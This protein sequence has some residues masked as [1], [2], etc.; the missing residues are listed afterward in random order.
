MQSRLALSATLFLAICSVIFS[1][2]GTPYGHSYRY[3]IAWLISF[4][5]AI[6]QGALYPRHLPE[7]WTGAGG[8]D[9]FFYG[10]L[11]FFMAAGPARLL[12]PS[13]E[14]QA[15]LS[16]AGGLL[17]ALS[18][19]AFYLFSRRFL[20]IRP[21]LVAAL[22]YALMPYHLGVDWFV[23]QAIGEFAAYVFVPLAAA[24]L[25]SALRD[26]R[27]GLAFPLGVAGTILCH[28]PTALLAAHVFGAV[29]L[30]WAVGYRT[31]V[32]AAA[33]RVA[34]MGIAGL[35]LAGLYWVPALVLLPDV[36]PDA[37]YQ[38]H[39][40]ATRWLFFDGTDA[41]DPRTARLVAI[42]LSAAVVVVALAT[43]LSPRRQRG[44]VLLWAALPTLLC[45]VLM[46]AAAR[47]LWEHWVIASVQFPWRLMVFVDLS[48]AL[49]VGVLVGAL[50]DTRRWIGRALP[51]AG[52]A[53]LLLGVAVTAPLAWH[54]AAIGIGLR[55]SDPRMTGAPEYLPQPFFAPIA[56]QVRAEGREMWQSR[57]AVSNA[58]ASARD[59][60]RG[61][62][63]LSIRPRA[64]TV[65]PQSVGTVVLPVPYWQHMRARTD[66]GETVPLH[67][68]DGSGLIAFTVP[69]D[70]QRIEIRLPWHWSEWAGAAMSVLGLVGLFAS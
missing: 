6:E 41:P 18:A 53:I 30:V 59:S 54:H 67:P 51:V 11:P 45:L 32:R 63:E 13:C 29:F 14:P 34:A 19:I 4:E 58:L 60:T 66:R 21:S 27:A 46:T 42:G 22:A 39:M 1:I 64:W 20:G 2:L 28:L 52:I 16:L 35:A 5:A 7:L 26:G 40:T 3:N 23:R 68:S 65:V 55:G 56:E 62:A 9:F 47:P 17:L 36:S 57:I 70:A 50:G 69:P 31:A 24:G 61:T 33:L 48:A 15:V 12:C 10:P 49:A 44:W 37:L 43:A 38:P 8:L 25:V